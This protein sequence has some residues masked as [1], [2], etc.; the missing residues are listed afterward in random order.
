MKNSQINQPLVS[1]IIPNYNHARYLDRRIQSVLNQTYRNIEVIILDDCSSDNSIE[2]I[3]KYRDDDR[4]AHVIINEKNSGNTFLQWDKGL[5]LA[6]GEIV[7]IAESDDYCEL[8]ML[9]V[10]VNAFL[11]RKRNVLAYSTTWYVDDSGNKWEG[12]KEGRTQ[13]F[14]GRNFLK[15]FFLLGN[16]VLNASCA[17]FSRECALS[18]DKK[19]QQ[20]KGIGDYWFWLMIAEQGCVTIIN[21][22]LNYFRRHAGVVT[23]RCVSSGVSLF[24]ERA[25]VDYII[26]KYKVS[27]IRQTY[28]FQYHATCKRGLQFDTEEIHEKVVDIWEINKQYSSLDKFIFRVASYFRRHFLLYF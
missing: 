24:D 23:D 13:H 28:V 7:W 15:K 10:L 4:I 3:D 16:S 11:S 25:L 20:Y 5:H 1:V 17:V 18:I 27:K 22:H 12:S 21:R 6:K 8:N 19:Y 14:S 2:V 26:N 9:E